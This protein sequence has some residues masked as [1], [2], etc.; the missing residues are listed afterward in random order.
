LDR[1]KLIKRLMVTFLEELQDHVR[2]FNR[3]LLA[4]E[5]QP[6]GPVADEAIK[7]LFRAAHSLKGAARSVEA[8]RL[9]GLCHQLE[10]LLA[11]LRDGKRELD[12]EVFRQLFAGVDGFEAAGKELRAAAAVP[13]PIP[14][15]GPARPTA[16]E[17]PL[18][19]APRSALTPVGR[20]E[21]E[22]SAVPAQ[23]LAQQRTTQAQAD[24]NVVAASPA[25]P[26]AVPAAPASQPTQPTRSMQMVPAPPG[27]RAPAANQVAA[28]TA[29][30]ASEDDS[31]V[32]RVT[33]RRLDALLAQSGELLAARRRFD[34]RQSDVSSLQELVDR[35]RREWTLAHQALGSSLRRHASGDG[36]AVAVLPGRLERFVKGCG[37]HLAHLERELDRLSLT[38]AEDRRMLERAASPL[39]HQ[40]HQARLVPFVEACEGLFRTVRD[41]ATTQSKEVELS[42]AGGDTELDRSIIDGLRAPLLHLIR[43]AV[44]HGAELPDE[45][46]AQGKPRRAT[47]SVSA[48]LRG[49]AVELIVSDDGRGIG[50]DAIRQQLR[51]RGMDVP[52][53]DDEL[54]RVIFQAGFSTAAE[55]THVSGRGVGL[56]VVKA[57]IEAMRGSVSLSSR[58][59]AGTRFAFMLPL[60]LTTLRVLFVKV[61]GECFALP[62]TSVSRLVRASAK[63]LGSVEARDMLLA[64]GAP[65][66]LVSLAQTLSLPRPPTPPRENEKIA[67]VVISADGAE[68][69]LAVDELLGE[70]EVVIKP[71]GRRLRRTQHIAGA[72]ILPTGGIGLVLKPLEVARSAL[73]RAPSLEWSQSFSASAPKA[74][75][76]LLLVDDSI[77]TRTLEK[78]ILEAAGYEVATGVDGAAA[79]QLLQEQGADLVVSDVEMPNMDGFT[80]TETIRK[81]KRFKD[82]PVI[83]VTAL[84]S[85]RD[86]ARGMESGADAYLLKTAFDQKV[87]LET[88][89]QLL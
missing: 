79:W 86:R 19:R 43:N 2:T 6:T 20:G 14:A 80:L 62:T 46:A 81:S 70:Q 50:H 69:A 15:S 84:H 49:D 66:P 64:S 75:K 88:I 54:A 1:D 28:P 8:K 23:P 87:L 56:D 77:T 63:D 13:A 32:V 39:Q 68:V 36:V 85:E 47:I 22:A 38:L 74:A 27:A 78:S 55:L 82:L 57:Q 60:T 16:V 37:E 67:I 65:I 89:R 53:D 59:G 17:R 58:R 24:E 7:V 5:Q 48:A 41:L 4:L 51:Q 71:L 29:R 18:E 12:A 11:A 76:R 35:F 73:G 72:T 21:S 33:G 26:V 52:S 30:E 10:E 34:E 3:E 40:I 42:I 9:E 31:G 83:L 44:S 45:R 25:K 61:G